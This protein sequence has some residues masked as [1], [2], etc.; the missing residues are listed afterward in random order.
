MKFNI[1]IEYIKL[2][3]L[4]FYPNLFNIYYFQ[5]YNDFILD[6]MINFFRLYNSFKYYF[7]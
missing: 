6:L 4:I 5:V 3:Y 2:K 1:L 7:L